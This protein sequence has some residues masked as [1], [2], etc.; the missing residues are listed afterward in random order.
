M[1][2]WL[3]IY[4]LKGIK[5]FNEIKVNT[6]IYYLR[7]V[8]KVLQLLPKSIEGSFMAQLLYLSVSHDWI[9]VTLEILCNTLKIIT[10]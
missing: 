5:I 4:S 3:V 10:T 8:L 9:I 6:K 1:N 2:N 7:H